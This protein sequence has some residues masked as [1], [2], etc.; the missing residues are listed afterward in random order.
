VRPVARTT[1]SQDRERYGRHAWLREQ[2]IYAVG[3]FRFG[4]WADARGGLL[5]RGLDRVYWPVYRVVET[6]TGISLDKATVVGPGLRI[7]HFGAVVVHPDAR[8]G[9]RCTLRQG[10][11]VGERR[12]GGGAPVIGDD[13]T[14]GA[15]AHVLGAIQ[16]GDGARIG[17][18]ALVIEDVPAGATVVAPAARVL[19]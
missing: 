17:A 13:V 12:D 4:Q 8:I 19:P 7:H 9:A 11:T 10:V 3:L 14:L 15:H 5:A 6:L 2:S 16:I 1:W 18:M